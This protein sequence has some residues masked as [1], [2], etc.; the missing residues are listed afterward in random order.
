MNFG[1]SFQKIIEAAIKKFQ[2]FA[3]MK[4]FR[5]KKKAAM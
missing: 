4:N 3:T 1:N 5:Q 2:N